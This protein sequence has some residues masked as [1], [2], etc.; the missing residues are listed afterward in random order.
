MRMKLDWFLDSRKSVM[1]TSFF[2]F[3]RPGVLYAE[4][5]H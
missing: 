2:L 3:R 5:I 1:K 4:D